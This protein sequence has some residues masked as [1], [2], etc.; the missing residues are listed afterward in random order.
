MTHFHPARA[1][2]WFALAA[3]VVAQ[4]PYV[5]TIIHVNVPGHPTNVVPGTGGLPFKPG[6]ITT[7][8]GRP[9]ASANGLHF[10][11]NCTTNEAAALDD[12]LLLDGALL[13]KEGNPA[14]WLASENI[15]TIDEE[16]G[17]NNAGDILLGN[18]T[19]AAANDDVIAYYQAGVWS[20][21]AREAGL[22][23][24]LLPGLVGDAGS[25]ATW[26][27]TID[28]V[29][30][31][32][33]GTALWRATGIDNLTT[34]TTN[35]AV[36]YL[37]GGLGLQ[38]GVTV[39]ANQAGAATNAWETFDLED[40]YVSPDGSLVMVQGDLVGTTTSDDVLVLNGVVVVQEGSVL[41]GSAFAEPVD[42]DG[43]VKGWVDHAGNWYARG[44]NDVTEDDWVLRNGVVVADSTGT[45]E[46]FAGAGEHWTDAAS[47]G[48]LDCFFGFDGNSLGHY[49][50]G[51]V[52]DHVDPLRN[53]VIVFHDGLGNDYVAVREG[54]PI[55]L[56][57]NGL[58]DDDR[59]YNTFGNDDVLLL[60]DGTIVFTATLRNGA[61][62]ATDQ[63][64]FRL[65]PT[66]ASCT[67]R[68]GSGINPVALSC[69]TLPIVGATWQVGLTGGPNTLA[70]FLYADPTPIPAF[71]LFGGE[72]LIAPTAFEIPTT[73]ALPY[74]YQ[75]L[76]FSLQGIRLD[77][78]GVN[79]AIV[80]TN[81]Q[82]TVL[83]Y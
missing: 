17:L 3:P 13:L 39:P 69:V 70:T 78:D 23:S 9:I 15:G 72:L 41:S 80:L 54:D 2:A 30:L 81:A 35:D 25:T 63:G 55:D 47:A 8:F 82:D 48:F 38:K 27:D 73:L 46:I 64:L 67:F 74:G 79:L 51:G 75:G 19:S 29:R 44:N 56:D 24:T 28:S 50:I 5:T 66:S 4:S 42:T 18:N 83:G 7:A 59:F 60:D 6:N 76:Q 77:F 34:G 36:V 14:P 58:F 40:V 57:G 53:G 16:F 11:I 68:N 10:A 32:N 49:V 12:V 62:T 21:L 20:E 26:D 33:T 52:T 43:I 45:D 65:T 71:P 1:A 22:V 37:G 31:T 61:G